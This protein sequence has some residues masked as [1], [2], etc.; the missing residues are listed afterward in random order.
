MLQSF[1]KSNGSKANKNKYNSP[2]STFHLQDLLP[3]NTFNVL[4]VYFDICHC[5]SK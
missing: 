1:K 4:A 2:V 5:I 3:R